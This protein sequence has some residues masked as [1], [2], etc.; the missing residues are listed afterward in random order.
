MLIANATVVTLG[1]QPAIRD[2]HGLYIDGGKIAALGKTAK[3]RARYPD[4]EIMDAGGQLVMPG[5]ICAHTH[6]Y[7]AYARGMAIPAP[8]P[9]D[10]PEILRKLWWNLDRAL[11]RDSVRASALVCLLDAVKHGATSLIDHHA[12]PNC[13]DGSLDIIGAA[14]EQAGLR[15]VLCY[16]VSDRDGEEKMRA[17]IAENLRFLAATANHPQLRGSFGLHASLTLSDETLRACA[18]AAPADA[19]FHIHVAEHEADEED[20]LRRSGMRVAQ[21]LD[22]YGIWRRNT[23]A[24]HCVHIDRAERDLLRE[25]GVWVSHQPRSNMNNGV[26]AADIDGM[27]AAGMPLCLGND[28][29]SNNMWAEWK[30]AYL[31]HKVSNRDPRR[32]DGGDIARMAWVNNAALMRQFFPELSI[33]EI[34]QGAAA[35]IIFVDYKPFTPLTAGNL[36]WHLL[37]GFEA[38]MVTTTI[39]AGKVLMRDRQLLTLDEDEI[40]AAAPGFGAGRLATL[41]AAC[42]RQPGLR[43]STNRKD[44][45]MKTLAILGGTGKEG[46]GLALRWA[47]HGYRVIIGSR[48]PK[49]AESR[50]AEMSAE[51][52]DACI[53][54]MGNADAA[55]AADIVILSV[56]YSAHAATLQSVREQCAGKALVDLT[57]PLQPP[58]IS[59]VNLPPGQAA[60]LEAQALLGESVTVVAAF[61]NVSAVKLRQLDR[62]VDCDVLVCADDA[63]AK[64]ATIEL[65]SAAGMRGIDAG[66]LKNAVAAE[67]L[68]PV[69][70]H[71]NRK[72]GVKG[73]GIRI[74]GLG[75]DS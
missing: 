26:G 65:V 66:G 20:S 7:G 11:D 43:H 41:R 27:L 60:A 10:F 21:R 57:V 56:P 54:G 55:A 48:S 5:G 8:A 39:C 68:T 9:R 62:P 38:S 36:P 24:A 71:I 50:A 1:A 19:G 67:S 44:I 22:Q 17:G 32:A 49:R 16:E 37:F 12:S 46:A 63:D 42:G 45:D 74:T 34:A 29:F 70:M 15:G 25:R 64:A 23:I 14:V 47:R 6:F 53:E 3:M 73:A 4:A 72:Y 59:S 2:D 75:A 30:A 33:G 61:Q 28:G 31:L 69:L 58:Q 18:D 52:G 51:L 35:D 13:I 40:A